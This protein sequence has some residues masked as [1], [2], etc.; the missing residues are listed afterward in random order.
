V[1]K[2]TVANGDGEEGEEEEAEF[3]EGVGSGASGTV[4]LQGSSSSSSSSSSSAVA[5]EEASPESLRIAQAEA[6]LDKI[7]LKLM[8]HLMG[9]L[10]YI[11]DLGEGGVDGGPGGA[12]A[13]AAGAAGLAGGA[14]SKAAAAAMAAAAASNAAVRMPLNQLTWQELARIV[15]VH[16]LCQEQGLDKE[17]IQHAIRGAK[18]T[19]Y[20]RTVKNVARDIRYRMAVRTL[21]PAASAVSALT[22]V[23]SETASASVEAPARSDV[24]LRTVNGAGVSFVDTLVTAEQHLACIAAMTS[25][26]SSSCCNKKNGAET[27]SFP[28]SSLTVAQLASLQQ[29]IEYQNNLF[30]TE[31]EVIQALEQVCSGPSSSGSGPEE[32]SEMYQRCSK[33]LIR[34]L[35]LAQSRNLMWEVDSSLYPDY[36]TAIRRPVMYTSVAACLVNKQYSFSVDGV[37]ADAVVA[38]LF[39][40]DALQVPT[41]CVTYNTEITP[42]VA[43]AYKMLHATHR[44]LDRWIHAPARPKLTF[45][46]DHFCLLTQEYIDPSDSVKC[47]KCCGAYSVSALETGCNE[48]GGSTAT[49]ALCAAYRNYYVSPT[50]EIRDQQ[51]EEWICPMCLH[52]MSHSSQ[53]YRNKALSDASLVAVQSTPFAVNEWGF[54]SKLP[55]MWHP[56]HSTISSGFFGEMSYL[57]PYFNALRVL[58]NE[59]ISA[60]LP[61]TAAASSGTRYGPGARQQHQGG[62]K[63]TAL[64]L[65]TQ[66]QQVQ[67]YAPQPWSFEE[68]VTV[69]LA[70]INVFRSTDK[71]MEFMQNIN[72]DCDKL[73]KIS[74]KPNFREA[75]FMGVVKVN[76]DKL[77]L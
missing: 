63:H 18:G 30:T 5:A 67:Q 11:L 59:R 2:K 37:H 26:H 52:E 68:R 46:S 47:G 40:S 48:V 75:D 12:D 42:V 58:S 64:P 71:S 55:W 73:V 45:L 56:E 70:L 22:T 32:Y 25:A 7:Q 29:H 34:L 41:N 27:A 60:V 23:S 10:K 74:S 66:E 61:T 24:V 76:L 49:A 35:S 6:E 17:T 19:S 43:Q 16:H 9:E 8:R 14:K 3:D 1:S 39:A 54:S 69:L 51:Q 13:G 20:F 50:Q 33:V 77:D 15:L 44:L 72:A 62:R 65:T 28:A 4:Q 38:A 36:Y 21:Q 31:K 53:L 57:A